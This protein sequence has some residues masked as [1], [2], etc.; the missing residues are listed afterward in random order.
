MNLGENIVHYAYG[1]KTKNDLMFDFMRDMMVTFDP[2]GGGSPSLVNYAP[3]VAAPFVQVNLN[4]NWLNDRI[5]KRE[6]P[7]LPDYLQGNYSTDE[8]YN[9]LTEIMYGNFG[10]DWNPSNVEYV[11]ES[12]ALAGPL[13][14]FK[15]AYE[16]ITDE[17]MTNK[18]KKL[19]E[20]FLTGRL[21]SD[22]TEDQKAYLYNFYDIFEKNPSRGLT[23]KELEYYFESGKILMKM[24]K[25][26]PE[27]FENGIEN[28]LRNYDWITPDILAASANR[29]V[30]AA[31]KTI[32]KYGFKI[33]AEEVKEKVIKKTQREIRID[34]PII[35][36]VT[37]KE[38]EPPK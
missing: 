13:G 30:A 27:V 8:N 31:D 16:V 18:G 12:Y 26:S 28:L 21:N 19:V 37:G 25:L 11:V 36:K 15:D 23:Q 4:T 17:G 33:D 38:Y 14:D 2:I 29:G 7:G 20:T 32:E 5:V 24:N 22:F 6:Q 3:T 9:R 35:E 34:N 10:I 1:Y